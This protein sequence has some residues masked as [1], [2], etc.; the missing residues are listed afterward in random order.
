MTEEIKKKKVEIVRL[1]LRIVITYS[2]VL[3]I[4]SRKGGIPREHLY[5]QLC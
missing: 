5:F 1:S 3:R 2:A 4:K